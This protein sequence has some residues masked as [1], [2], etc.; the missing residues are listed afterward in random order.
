MWLIQYISSIF[1][2]SRENA[3]LAIIFYKKREIFSF[4]SACGISLGNVYK[5]NAAT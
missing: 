5:S 1:P 4:V 2:V 3:V